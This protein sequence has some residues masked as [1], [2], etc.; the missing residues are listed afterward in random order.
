MQ[1]ELFKPYWIYNI[2]GLTLTVRLRNYSTFAVSC[3][4]LHEPL[5]KSK[6][7]LPKMLKNAQPTLS[8]PYKI[9]S[10]CGRRATR[11]LPIYM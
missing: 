1:G 4:C 5:D 10:L 9:F 2:Y 3:N 7:W 6:L 11:T 8:H